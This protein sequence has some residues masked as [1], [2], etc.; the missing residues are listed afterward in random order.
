MSPLPCKNGG[1]G[2]AHSS[3]VD[4]AHQARMVADLFPQKLRVHP[5]S[6]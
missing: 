3:G 4:V 5:V 2:N 6:F 1:Y